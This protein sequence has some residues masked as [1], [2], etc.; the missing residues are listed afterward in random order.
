MA[1]AERKQLHA[2]PRIGDEQSK[3]D[4]ADARAR[5]VEPGRQKVARERL[6]LHGPGARLR[7]RTRAGGLE[8]DAEVRR[9]MASQQENRAV[10]QGVQKPEARPRAERGLR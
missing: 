8:I 10:R 6:E 3:R 7:R 1:D 2:E 9:Q 4:G 5:T